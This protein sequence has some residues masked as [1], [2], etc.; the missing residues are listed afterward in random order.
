MLKKAMLKWER[1]SV[2][3]VSLEKIHFNEFMSNNM[4][5]F[6]NKNSFVAPF[7]KIKIG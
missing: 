6:S 2:F 4:L 7:E 1:N 3:K 5:S